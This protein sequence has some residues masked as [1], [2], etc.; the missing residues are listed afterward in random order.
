MSAHTS[1]GCVGCPTGFLDFM[2]HIGKPMNPVWYEKYNRLLDS[3]DRLNRW[4]R[5]HLPHLT[6]GR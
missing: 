4:Q 6:R 1:V 3:R 2:A 5:V